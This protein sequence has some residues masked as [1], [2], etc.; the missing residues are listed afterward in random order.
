MGSGSLLEFGSIG[1]I[2]GYM[3][4]EKTLTSTL[5][6]QWGTSTA[7]I[8]NWYGAI[9]MGFN[10]NVASSNA[11]GVLN[12]KLTDPA[13]QTVFNDLASIGIL[14]TTA[15]SGSGSGSVTYSTKTLTTRAPAGGL[16]FI[17]MG[18]FR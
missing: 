8:C 12:I 1:P 2:Y 4:I 14:H 16:Q 13:T 7:N 18:E 3:D 11:G 10:P 5:M 15:G 17:R 6:L 9:S